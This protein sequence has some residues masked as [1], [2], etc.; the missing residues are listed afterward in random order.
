MAGLKDV[1]E[2]LLQ[3]AAAHLKPG[4]RP[5]PRN[6]DE[7]MQAAQAAG[8]GIESAGRPRSTISS[9]LV[10]DERTV[11]TIDAPLKKGGTGRVGYKLDTFTPE[12]LARGRKRD[13]LLFGVM[14]TEAQRDPTWAQHFID[15]ARSGANFSVID[16]LD[17]TKAVKGTGEAL[18][19]WL[20]DTILTK[21]DNNIVTGLTNQNVRRWPY[22]NIKQMLRAQAG[23]RD[24]SQHMAYPYDLFVDPT[25]AST[26]GQAGA[27]EQLLDLANS[28]GN[29]AAAQAMRNRALRRQRFMGML[30]DEWSGD[31]QKRQAEGAL[32]LMSGE[33]EAL[34]AKGVEDPYTAPGLM[35]SPLSTP[36]IVQVLRAAGGEQ[37]GDRTI[38]LLRAIRAAEQGADPAA[39]GL[40]AFRR[41]GLVAL[42]RARQTLPR[43]ARTSPCG[44]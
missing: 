43:Q 26:Q 8:V 37:I 31:I 19:P 33:D 35:Q 7:L 34:R 2:Y 32:K 38:N 11:F 42:A 27:L 10:P 12:T 23:G 29:A 30:D 6:L 1:A 24:W 15:N 17:S 16:A 44:G 39:A 9:V 20:Y 5:I 40:P 18:Y 4:T 3:N 28:Q 14:P 41:G 21:G 22:N 25:H 13:D 36:E